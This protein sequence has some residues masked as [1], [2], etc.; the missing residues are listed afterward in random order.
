MTRLLTLLLL[1]TPLAAHAYDTPAMGWSSWNTYRVNISDSLI[2]AQAD[3]MKALGLDTLGY[4]YINIDDGYF[5]GRDAVTGRLLIHPTR[6]PGGMKP[7]V[8]HI[9]SLGLK[10]GI[11]SDAGA[12]T[13]GNFWDNDTIARGVGLLGHEEADCH[14]FFNELGFDF[15]KVDFCG[16]DGR[17]T[18]DL[19]HAEPRERYT[20]I[21]EAIRATGRD[22]VRLNVCRWD[23]PGTWV[24]DVASSW[25]TTHDISPTWQSVKAIIAE[26]LYMA[27]YAGEGRFNDMDM[28]EIGRGMGPE[29]DL[30]HF[31]IWCIM[32][33]PLM[34]GC[35]LTSLSPSTLA[36]LSNR[37]LIA[38][39]QDPLAVQAYVAKQCDGAYVLVKDV[40][41][42]RGLSRAVALYNPTDTT[43]VVCLTPGEVELGG[44]VTARDLIHH[45]PATLDNGQLTVAIPP[46]ATRAYRLDGTIRH[47]RTRYEA[48]HAYLGSYQE[49]YDPLAVGTAF[50]LP[51]KGASGGMVVANLGHTPSNDMT[52]R[53]VTVGTTGRYTVSIAVRGNEKGEMIVSANDSPGVKAVYDGNGEATL[54]VSLPL[55]A[56][57]NSIRISATGAAPAIDYIDVIL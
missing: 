11:Y 2:M 39:N 35:D 27:P 6:F 51:A 3:A 30:T 16:A 28:L 33:S 25:R 29:E 32:S 12:N 45:C 40:G 57:T 8:D 41:A 22:D 38:L 18:Y 55:S 43:R 20:A 50:Y 53:D 24:S 56:G 15:I 36:I 7:V 49:I 37:E 21:S 13:C 47:P 19:Y 44:D 26:N 54:T 46:H 48:E 5:G 34:I 1:L 42:A 52:W 14:M 23:Y 17:Q 9:H 31:A 4:R 10:A